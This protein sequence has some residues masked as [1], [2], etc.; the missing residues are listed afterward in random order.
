MAQAQNISAADELSLPVCIIG[1][2]SSGVVVAKHLKQSGVPFECFEI[3]SDIGGMWRYQND[4][5]LSSAYRSLHID[6]SRFNLG[7]SDHPI[8]DHY[9]DFLSHYQVM[10][11]LESYASRFEVSPH[12]RFNAEVQDVKLLEDKSW[13]VTLAD[14]TAKRYRAV[15]VANGHLWDPRWAD[16]EGSF[17]GEQIHSHHYRTADPFKDKNVLV[18]GIGNSAVDVAVDVCK[19][20]KSTLLSTRRSAW[21]MPKYIMGL[22][23]DR[24]LAFFSR[25]LHLPV[26]LSRTIVQKIAYLVTGDQRRFGIPSPKHPV[27]REHATLSQELIPFCGHGWIRMKPNVSHLDGSQ[28]LFDDGSSEPVDVIIHAT[29]YKTSFPFLE[30]GLFQVK[31]GKVELYRRMAPPSLPGLYFAGLVQ[32]VGPTIPLVEVQGRWLASV[33]SGNTKLPPVAGMHEEIRQ[34]N[35][36][37][38]KRYVGSARYTLEVDYKRYAQQ[39]RADIAD[40]TARLIG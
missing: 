31:D 13:Q 3:G 25:K 33:L 17:D 36:E 10:D 32:P 37:I 21:I 19:S 5:G 8:P 28:V 15:V 14:G 29:G 2:G 18:I 12:I 24:W 40:Q 9:P 16:F 23:I 35:D 38:A 27:W 7:Y 11:Y 30:P 39:L 34:H 22:P 1:A 26:P 4:N 6:T 20:A